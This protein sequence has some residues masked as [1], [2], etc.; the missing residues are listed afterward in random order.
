[1]NKGG[2]LRY[3]VLSLTRYGILGASSRLRS[4]QYFKKLAKSNFIVKNNAII[5]DEMLSHRYGFLSYSYYSVLASY[6]RR[7]FLKKS[8]FDI[9]LVEKEVFPWAPYF[10]DKFF[11]RSSV[12]VLDYDDA[13]F[14]YYDN[15]KY[16]FIR[17]FLGNKIDKLMKHSHLVIAGNS[18]ILKRALNAGAKNVILLPTVVDLD[19]YDIYTNKIIKNNNTIIVWIGSP[20]TVKYLKILAEPL[21]LLSKKYDFTF[22]IIGADYDIPGVKTEICEWSELSEFNLL[23]TSTIGVMPLFNTKWE[24]GKC[25]Y[26]IIQY[27]ACS[28]PVVAS[29]VGAN[30]DVLQDGI[31]GFF[32]EDTSTW[33]ATL[34]TLI[35]DKQLCNYLGSKGRLVVESKYSLEVSSQVM[36]DSLQNL[37]S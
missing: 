21:L 4:F 36:I 10:L 11:L 30:L 32:A 23:S 25:A 2:V 15:S 29:P 12:Y 18:Y 27:M 19:K 16:F 35:L 13:I 5:D 26:K 3:C 1:M 33:F 17:F 6:L 20:S 14:H 34:E 24:L 37:C 31:T 22:R 7:F 9:L 28:L 8:N